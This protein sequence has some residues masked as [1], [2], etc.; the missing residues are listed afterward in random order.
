MSYIKLTN[1]AVLTV[2][3]ADRAKFLQGL[4]SNDTAKVTDDKLVYALLLTPQGKYYCDL[5]IWQDGECFF[6]DCPS[7][8]LEPLT[9]KLNMYKLRSDVKIAPSEMCVMASFEEVADCQSFADP[10][11]PELG[12][13]LYGQWDNVTQATQYNDKRISLGVP[14]HGQDLIPDKSIPLECHMD[15]ELSIP[16]VEEL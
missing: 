12:Y 10:R 13:R 7:D 11:E 9:K 4:V 2:C 8:K 6:V 15:K 5:F 1:R 3:G 14:E 16:L